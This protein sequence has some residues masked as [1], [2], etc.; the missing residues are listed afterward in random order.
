M[1]KAAANERSTV[2]RSS[3]EQLG[4]S[5]SHQQ[6]TNIHKDAR[7]RTDQSRCASDSPQN[8]TE[9]F[10]DGP[11]DFPARPAAGRGSADWLMASVLAAGSQWRLGG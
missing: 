1:Y 6:N 5:V 9:L 11:T 3:P 7:E 10:A 2:S 4:S 8:L